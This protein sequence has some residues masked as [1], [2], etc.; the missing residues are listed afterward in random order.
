MEANPKIYCRFCVDPSPTSL[1]VDLTSDTKK[2]DSVLKKLNKISLNVDFGALLPKT[3]CSDC[4]NVLTNIYTYVLKVEAS[5]KILNRLFLTVELEADIKLEE[6]SPDECD[7]PDF[8]DADLIDLKADKSQNID[9][10]GIIEKTW[11]TY[12][13]LCKFCLEKF[14]NLS[15]LRSHC[16]IIHSEC[17]GLYCDSCKMPFDKFEEFTQHV[18]AHSISLKNYCPYCNERIPKTMH[19]K[20]HMKMHTEEPN[21]V[22]ISCG[23]M[24]ESDRELMRHE[25]AYKALTK[26]TSKEYHLKC[27]I[28]YKEFKSRGG[29]L[30][31]QRVHNVDRTPDQHCEQCGKMFL[32]K[33][34]LAKHKLLHTGIKPHVCKICN[35]SF[36]SLAKL[37]LHVD[38]HTGFK[39]FSCETCKRTFRLKDQL[40]KHAIT[41]TEEKPFKCSECDKSFRFK[42]LLEVHVRQHTGQQPYHCVECDKYFVNSS[43]FHKHN[44]R[45]HKSKGTKQVAEQMKG[46]DEQWR[47]EVMKLVKDGSSHKKKKSRDK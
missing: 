10:D 32:S 34:S 16:K 1:I 45:K 17:N 46:E 11:D 21:G 28:C 22:C 12:E 5:Q 41:H 37:R 40:K 13:W 9:K 33:N 18:T 42:N 25:T 43:N 27:N 36:V 29:R 4:Y 38:V 6:L 39:P 30:N 24:F 31:H 7:F 2:Y 14:S 15:D 3:I 35:K 47:E 26:A 44:V 19:I 20:T 23:E 8:E